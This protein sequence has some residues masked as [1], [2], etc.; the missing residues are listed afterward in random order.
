MLIWIGDFGLFGFLRYPKCLEHGWHLEDT[1]LIFVEWK[2][3]GI[4]TIKRVTDWTIWSAFLF[5]FVIS[6]I[7]FRLGTDNKCWYFSL[8]SILLCK[9][10]FSTLLFFS[11]LL[12]L[13]VWNNPRSKGIINYFCFIFSALKILGPEMLFVK[14]TFLGSFISIICTD[15]WQDITALYDASNISHLSGSY[16]DKHITYI[17]S[18]L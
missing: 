9:L 6:F 11:G 16:G 3:L 5:C 2:N 4:V 18:N 17:S 1:L 15:T 14:P 7:S 12:H 13:G 10:L 8:L